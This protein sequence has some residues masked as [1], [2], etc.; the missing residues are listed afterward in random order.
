MKKNIIITGGNGFIGQNF[1]K[2]LSPKKF[3]IV[4]IDCLSD[5]SDKFVNKKFKWVKFKK[6][7]L[8]NSKKIKDVFHTFDPD[9]V[10]NFAAHSH[11]DN[12]ILNNKIFMENINGTH[13]LLENSLKIFQKKKRFKYL[14][15]STDEVFGSIKI[16]KFNSKSPYRPNSPYSASKAASDHLVRAFNKTYGLPTTITYSCNNYGPFQHIEKLIP[17]T[18]YSYLNKTKMGIYGKGNQKRQWI[19]VEDN[20]DA[21]M[22]VLESNFNGSTYCIGS[23]YEIDNLSLVKK[24][25]NI[26]HNK[27]KIKKKI[28]YSDHLKFVKDRPG[29]DLRYFLEYKSF[30]KKFKWH[31]NTSMDLGLRKTV[32]WFLN[33]PKWIKQKKSKVIK[34]F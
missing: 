34:F 33:N 22:K 10:V 3:N 16:G 28:N 15:V 19:Y 14:Q 6:I 27:F 8:C 11:V 24:I 13:I 18:I 31:Q 32:E 7:N 20:T 12:S 9:L 2:K 30:S 23:K 17:L 1:L 25:L 26:L 29:H 4:N 21:L 5:A